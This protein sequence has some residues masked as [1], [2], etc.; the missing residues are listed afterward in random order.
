MDVVIFGTGRLASLAWFALGRDA[1]YRVVGFTADRAYVTDREKHGLPVVPFEDLEEFFPAGRTAMIAPLGFEITKGLAAA[2]RASANERGYSSLSHVSPRAVISPDLAVGTNC[3]VFDGVV[4]EPF[5][6]IG[7]DV[8]VRGG[9]FLSHDVSIG[10]GCFVG[11]RATL[12][13][14][15][16]IGERSFLAIGVTVQ[17]RVRVAPG[18]FIAAGALV[19]RDTDENGVYSG[20]PAVRRKMPPARIPRI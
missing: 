9:S 13:G 12:G 10:N 1:Q 6:S 3:I 19:T 15:V 11:P 14:A 4:V 2:R 18:C 17:P 16:T 7:D 5:V 8:V 20:A